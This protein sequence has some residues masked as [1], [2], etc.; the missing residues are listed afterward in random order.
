MAIVATK[1]GGLIP[2]PGGP[3]RDDQGRMYVRALSYAQV[4]RIRDRF[5]ALKP[6]APD[7]VPGSILKHE[8]NAYCYA[9]AAKRYALYRYDEDGR[10]RLVP[11]DEHQPCSHGLGHLL[12]PTDPDREDR[13]WI[14]HFWEH[15]L[16]QQFTNEQQPALNWLDHPALGK[17]AITSPATWQQLFRFNDSKPYRDQIK[18]FGFLLHAPGADIQ[19][20]T[21]DGGRLVAPYTNHPDRWL[22]LDWV[23]LNRRDQTIKITTDPTRAGRA[24]IDTYEAIA[25][26]YFTHREAKAADPSGARAGRASHGLLHRRHVYAESVTIIGKEAND[27]GDRVTGLAPDP[28]GGPP[29]TIYRA[30]PAGALD[31]ADLDRLRRIGSTRLAA[32][33]GLSERRLRDILRGRASPRAATRRRLAAVLEEP[34]R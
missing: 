22:E 3:Y 18:P 20:A 30:G 28:D 26:T 13:D 21:G 24:L 15:H 5:A 12:N 1:R 16:A 29:V 34:D 27:L 10:P 11:D 6:Y 32:L 19:D 23:D 25:D 7:A 2:C 14:R 8:L 4:E 17:I 9:V 33:T 31:A